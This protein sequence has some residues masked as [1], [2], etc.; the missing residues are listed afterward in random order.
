MCANGG[1]F[2][3]ASL[4]LLLD[5]ELHHAALFIEESEVL[6]ILPAHVVNQLVVEG[7]EDALEHDILDRVVHC[8][9][10]LPRHRDLALVSASR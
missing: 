7:D 9:L 10:C 5:V 4:L 2:E 6:F 3:L 8:L 1:N